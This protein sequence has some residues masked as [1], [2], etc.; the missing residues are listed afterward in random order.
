MQFPEGK[1]F[2]F[3]ILDDTDDATL[4]NV[5]PAYDFLYEWGF[6]TTKTVWPMDCPEGSRLFFAGA[7][8]QDKPYLA[9]VHDL[10]D[11]GFELAFHGATMESSVRERTVRGLNFINQEFGI[12][13][14]LFCNHGYNRENLYWGSDRFRNSLLRA[15]FRLRSCS[16]EGLYAGA[17]EG[18]PF[19]WGDLC[20]A[21]IQYVRNFT[22]SRLNMMIVNP[23][24]PYRLTRTPYVNYWF[25][26]AEAPDVHGF[27][28]LLTRDQIDRLDGSGGV[29][30]ISTHLGKG[31]VNNGK[32]HEQTAQMLRYLRSKAGWFV[33]V[34]NILDH[35]RAQR[36]H[37]AELNW[38]QQT[39]LEYRF[40]FDK[41]RMIG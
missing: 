3:S 38:I 32:L 18:S 25:S 31:F 1:Q 12:Y 37:D 15:L 36:A 9:F 39:R 17:S 11:Q 35:L 26:T 23:E 4:A 16:S 7:T 40:L 30:I 24:M 6:R 22:F 10:V 27:N 8:L 28:R 20:K 41:L 19:F 33:P 5:K 13:P 14:R 21:H 29:C 2:A 34:S